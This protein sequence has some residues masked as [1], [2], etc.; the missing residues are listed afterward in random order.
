MRK[1]LLVAA[2]TLAMCGGARAQSN[3]ELKGML[4]Q[5]LRT[6]QDLQ[7]RVQALEAQQ[8]QGAPAL[9]TAPAPAATA[10]APA[11]PPAPVAAAQ[12]A[13]P[14]GDQPRVEFYGQVMLD[15][16]VDSR[17]MNPDWQ[18]TFRPSQIPVDCPADPGCGQAGAFHMS[19][20]QSSLGLRATVPTALG[21]VKTDLAFDLFGTDGSTSVHWLRAWAE[22]G[23]WGAGQTDSNFMDLDAF[24]NILDYGGPPG[25]VFLRNPQLRYTGA[26]REGMTWAASLEAPNSVLDTGRLTEVD[27]ALGA[28]ITAHNRLPDLVGSLRLDRPW[29]HAKAAA[30]LREVGYQTRTTPSGNPSGQRTGYGLN[31]TGVVNLSQRDRLGGGLVAGRAIAS[32]MNDG[33][34]DLAPDARL[35]AQAVPSLGWSA[36]WGHAWNAQWASSIGYSEHRQDNTG[37]QAGNAL[38]TGSYASANLLYTLAPNVLL[39]GEYLWGRRE[40]KDGGTGIDSRIQF[41]TR[42]SF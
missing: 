29:G 40:N 26:G 23:A 33:G 41:S 27:P 39:G 5:A 4:D 3:E 13:P 19:V 32:Y 38:R 28:G 30:I 18:A 1:S 22:M 10:A 31:F 25:M 36:Y 21:P 2:A 37:G 24:P 16:M 34:I 9:P 20:R 7:A 11:W 6:I 42:V 17:R 15:A 12:A 8:H 14:A 35:R